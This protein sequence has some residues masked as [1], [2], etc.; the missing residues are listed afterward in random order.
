MRIG[1]MRIMSKRKNSLIKQDM[2]SNVNF[3][4]GR[5]KADI[6]FRQRRVTKKNTRFGSR[7]QFV[8]V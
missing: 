4:R 1:K 6:P 3:V 2:T 5:I 7:L 8:F